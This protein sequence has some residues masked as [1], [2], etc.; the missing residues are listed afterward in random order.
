MELEQLLDFADQHGQL[1]RFVPRLQAAERERNGALAE[2]RVAYDLAGRR[3]ALVNWEP[4]GTGGTRGEFL[5]QHS[6]AVPIFTEVKAPDWHGQITGFRNIAGDPQRLAAVKQRKQEP[7]YKN[8]SGGPYDP[9]SGIEFAIQKAYDKLTPNQPNLLV[10]PSND[11]FTPC[12]HE[13]NMIAARRLFN[14]RNGLFSDGR[15]EKLGAVSL[16][17]FE[18]R[19]ENDEVVYDMETF[20]NPYS[21]PATALPAEVID[22]LHQR[23]P[24]KVGESPFWAVQ[25]RRQSVIARIL[26]A[27]RRA[28]RRLR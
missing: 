12:Q 16:F 17:W 25:R 5:I 23:L 4:A 3:F 15:F 7:K 20:Q 26:G 21:L 18:C 13:P 27:F 6:G 8:G 14:P 9:S 19:G 1:D 28:L 11:L 22:H 10:I 24:R 2:L